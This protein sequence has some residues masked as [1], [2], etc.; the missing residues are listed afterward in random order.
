MGKIVDT[1]IE[2][3]SLKGMK[4]KKKINGDQ[5]WKKFFHPELQICHPLT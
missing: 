4:G 1:V 2:I 5:E 3:F